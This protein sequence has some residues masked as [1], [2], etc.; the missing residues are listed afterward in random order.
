MKPKIKNVSTKAVSFIFAAFLTIA[1]PA[2]AHGA[3]LFISPPNEQVTVGQNFSVMVDMD[4]EGAPIN[5]AST[6]IKYDNSMLSIQSVGYSSSILTIWAEEPKYSNIN[7]ILHFSGGLPSPGWNGSNGP[8]LRITFSAKAKGQTKVVFANGSVLA[9]DGIGTD[10]LNS[11]NGLEISIGQA[12]PVLNTETVSTST[13]ATTTEIQSVS[14]APSIPVLSGIP[15]QL[16]EGSTLS[17]NGTGI[18]NGE[19]LVYIEKG[20]D[21]P[22]ITQVNTQTDGNF[23]IVYK[24]PVSSGYY[25]IWATSILSNGMMSNSSD[26]SY[27]EVV[28]SGSFSLG[29]VVI[30]YK[31]AIIS[32]LAIS[33][34]LLVLL[35]IVMVSHL[36]LRNKKAKEIADAKASLRKGF[37]TLKVGITSY[38]KYLTKSGQISGTK[39]KGDE[40][41]KEE[42]EENLLSIEKK[43][44][45][46]INDIK[47]I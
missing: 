21:N 46:G 7:G 29:G 28:S 19:V 22:E 47:N 5:A 15:D 8:L 27:V 3:T 14:I 10:V 43:I 44:E 6:D 42:L 30:T 45:K 12:I 18:S 39:K 24:S 34:I 33:V 26:V 40:D 9:N 36:A 1:F 11:S 13:I 35:V 25:K 4:S 20:K 31:S 32:L 37:D 17:F 41:V 38:I 23:S 16:T 2:L